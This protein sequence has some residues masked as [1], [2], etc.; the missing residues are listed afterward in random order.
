MKIRAVEYLGGKCIKCGYDECVEALDFH[1]LDA[2]SKEF[3][4]SGNFNRSWDS[5]RLELDKC[6]ILCAR[7]HREVEC[8]F[9]PCPVSITGVR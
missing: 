2:S 5:I 9:S 6:A 4:I 8:G 1:H 7:C 3:S